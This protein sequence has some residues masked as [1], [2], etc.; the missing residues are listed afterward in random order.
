MLSRC[1]N[2]QCSKRFLRL[3]E[4]KLFVVEAGL[5]KPNGQ[6]SQTPLQPRKQGQGVERY[7]LCDQCAAE[8]TLVYNW[9]RGI[10]LVPLTRPDAEAPAERDT[11]CG[12][13]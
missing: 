11:R 13:A 4:G 7:W 10:V 6:G 9:Q 1:A 5:P 12:V 8:W 2:S 3:R